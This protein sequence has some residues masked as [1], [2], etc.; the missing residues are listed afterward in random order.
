MII[1]CSDPSGVKVWVTQPGKTPGPAKTRAEGEGGCRVDSGGQEGEMV[2]EMWPWDQLSSQRTIIYPNTSSSE[3]PLK[4][5]KPTGPWGVA[6]CTR[7]DRVTMSI[8]LYDTG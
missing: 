6:P 4:E 1:K 5:G 8:C 7:E 3:L 2:R